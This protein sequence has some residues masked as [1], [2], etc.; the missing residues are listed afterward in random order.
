MFFNV[1]SAIFLTYTRKGL[2]VI[3]S[4]QHVQ[5][6][7]HYHNYKPAGQIETYTPTS[8]RRKWTPEA[9]RA[10]KPP[11]ATTVLP[12]GEHNSLSLH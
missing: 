10:L 9:T 5:L 3:V 1:S 2:I 11:P 8:H 4:R 7:T 12:P 6:H